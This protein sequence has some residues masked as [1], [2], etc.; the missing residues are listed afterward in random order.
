MGKLEDEYKEWNTPVIG[1]YLLWQFCIGYYENSERMPSIIETIF[2]YVLLTD[3]DYLDNITGHKPNFSSF[4]RS[5]TKEKQSDLLLCFSEKLKEKID[6]A[7]K[8][9]DIAVT[10]GLIAWDSENANLIPNLKV[11]NKRGTLQLGSAIKANKNKANL[12]GKWFSQNSIE[13][14]SSSLGV[15]L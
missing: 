14:I 9:V 6:Y 3:K 11:K 2:A 10:A 7:F 15:I 8:A 13:I 4:I 5:F 1:S 12:L